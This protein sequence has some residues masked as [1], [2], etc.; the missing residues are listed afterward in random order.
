MR[1]TR[2]RLLA[3][4]C[5][6]LL[7]GSVSPAFA[8]LHVDFDRDGAVDTVTLVSGERPDIR[9]AFPGA[10]QLLVLPLK[11]RVASASLDLHPHH[12]PDRI[13]IES[14]GGPEDHDSAP[15]AARP[16]WQPA[17]SGVNLFLPRSS[18]PDDASSLSS[19]SRAPP[20]LSH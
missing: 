5:I 10:R 4:A 18:L 11:D 16:V 17:L 14:A 20:A 7:W 8:L 19:G 1:P 13:D 12:T 9:I 3:I 15:A 2:A 6:F